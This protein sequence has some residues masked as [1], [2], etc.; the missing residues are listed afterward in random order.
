VFKVVFV[1]AIAPLIM[2]NNFAKQKEKEN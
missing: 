2:E 1:I